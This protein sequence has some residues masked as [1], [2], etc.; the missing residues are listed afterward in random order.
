MQTNPGGAR[1]RLL[2]YLAM[3]LGLAVVYFLAG[4][5]GL[6]LAFVNRS[7][8]SVWPPSGISIAAVLLLGYRVWPGISLG[9]FAV[10]ITTAGS[11]AT[12]LGIAT[13]KKP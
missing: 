13:G 5:L 10:N 4:K 8:T 12:C 11:V 7:V 9:A 3:L 2:P 6:S 1:R